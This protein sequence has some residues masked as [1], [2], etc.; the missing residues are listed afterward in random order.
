M[1]SK[2]GEP[3]DDESSS[4]TPGN[5]EELS[6]IRVSGTKVEYVVNIDENAGRGTATIKSPKVPRSKLSASSSSAPSFT[7]KNSG[8]D[9]DAQALD[10]FWLTGSGKLKDEQLRKIGRGWL[11]LSERRLHGFRIKEVQPRCSTLMD[12]GA[13]HHLRGQTIQVG[14]VKF[15][16]YQFHPAGHHQWAALRAD[17][18][19]SKDKFGPMGWQWMSGISSLR[20]DDQRY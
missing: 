17:Y 10:V 2:V 14:S 19:G 20:G 9:Q 1:T 12:G 6:E 3:L 13:F 7:Q 16:G 11:G 4:P 5:S 18:E 8:S 15:E